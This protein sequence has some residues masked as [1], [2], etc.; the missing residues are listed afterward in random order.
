MV[1]LLRRVGIIL[2]IRVVAKFVSYNFFVITT[3]I[4]DL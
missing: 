1:E 4:V 2:L 3:F